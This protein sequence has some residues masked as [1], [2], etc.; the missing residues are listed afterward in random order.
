M[1]LIYPAIDLLEGQCVRLYEGD[2]SKK[3]VYDSDPVQVAS[4][5]VKAGSPWIHVVDLEGARAGKPMQTE[6]ILTLQKESGA[7]IQAGGGLRS[8]ETVRCLLR[9]G[10]L[11][12]AIGSLAMKDKKATLELLEEFGP[13]RLTLALDIRFVDGV[14]RLTSQGWEKT[15]NAE[16]WPV[17]EFYQR[18]GFQHYLCTDVSKDG[19][20]KGPNLDL[21]KAIKRDFP[22]ISLQA[23]GGVSTLQDIANLKEIAV[24]GI[25]VGKALYEGVFT[26]EEAIAC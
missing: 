12:A 26:L 5:M 17:V 23:S 7:Q 13:E 8:L 18:A 11:R 21:Y 3:T 22:K 24:S 19:T 4:R 6:T 10:V 14:A 25:I 9:N 1:S 2:Y 20:L 15:E 16:L